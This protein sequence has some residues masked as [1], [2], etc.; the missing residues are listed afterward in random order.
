MGDAAP[1]LV[2][3]RRVGGDRLGALDAAR[4]ATARFP[5]T[6]DAWFL[7]GEAYQGAFKMKEA[8]DAFRSGRVAVLIASDIAARGLDIP[9]VTNI[10]NVDVPTQSKAYLHR[11]GRTGRAGARGEAIT[12]LTEAEVRLVRRFESE[13]GIVM[14]HV[15][16]REGRVIDADG[17]AHPHPPGRPERPDRSERPERPD[18][19]RRSGRPDQPRRPSTKRA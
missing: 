1:T 13:L 5:Q 16:L 19:S 11:V 14:R 17:P 9:G 7:L 12:L 3:L 15:R 4:A 6:A 8:M 18:S 10:F 2:A